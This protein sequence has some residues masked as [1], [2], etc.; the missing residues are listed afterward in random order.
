MKNGLFMYF[1]EEMI[2]DLRLNIL[3]KYIDYFVIVESKF[4]HRGEKREL[5]FNKNKFEH[6]KDKIIYLIHDEI[7]DNIEIIKSNDTED[8]KSRKLIMNA[9]FRENGQ[10]NYIRKGL[11]NAESEDIILISDVDEI[12]N[13]NDL[14]LIK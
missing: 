13:L 2:L 11:N 12:P 5:K 3:K 14:D 10:R 8:E 6:F 7:P 1:D 9:V 4:T